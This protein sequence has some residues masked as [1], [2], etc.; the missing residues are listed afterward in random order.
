[1]GG[2][3]LREPR[4]L[5]AFWRLARCWRRARRERQWIMSRRKAADEELARWFAFEPV[6]MAATTDDRDLAAMGS[7][8]F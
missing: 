8:I 5:E 3:L 2:C 6:A 1:M 4:S 7:N